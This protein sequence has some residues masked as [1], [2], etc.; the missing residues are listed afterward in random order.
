RTGGTGGRL[1]EPRLVCLPR[2]AS[3]DDG[4]AVAAVPAGGRQSRDVRRR[5]GGPPAAV[6]RAGRSPD[7]Q[8]AVRADAG[9]YGGSSGPGHRG[10]PRWA[11]D[12]S[13]AAA[14]EW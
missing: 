4:L 3:R 13:D 2:T 12:R 11:A 1:G 9:L 5:G 7:P 6:A 10:A 8:I 14:V